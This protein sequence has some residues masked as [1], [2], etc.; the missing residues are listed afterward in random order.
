[1]ANQ[2]FVRAKSCSSLTGLQYLFLQSLRNVTKI[3]NLSALSQLRRLHPENLKGPRDVSAI[4]HAPALEEFSHISAQNI[5]PEQSTDL[6][7]TPTLKSVHVGFGSQEKNETLAELAIRCG[8]G[9]DVGGNWQRNSF[10]CESYDI[11]KC[12]P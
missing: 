1:L 4:F 3:P 6:L 11:S 12:L 8:K 5:S 7:Q 9:L 10:F 2:G